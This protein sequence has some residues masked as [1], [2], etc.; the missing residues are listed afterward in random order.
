MANGSYALH[1]LLQMTPRQLVAF[2]R[3]AE[4]RTKHELANL[5]SL[6]LMASRGKPE[7]VVKAIREL[8]K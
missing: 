4:R 7:A 5:L 8:S 2:L 1:D 6:H 3:L